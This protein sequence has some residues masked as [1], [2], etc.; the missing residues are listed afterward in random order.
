MNKLT[1]IILLLGIGLFFYQD[2]FGQRLSD[3]KWLLGVWEQKT[4]KRV[5]YETWKRDNDTCYS[6]KSYSLKEKDTIV[7]ESVRLLQKSGTLYYIP[8]VTNQNSG[9][10][11][12]F[13]LVFSSPGQLVFENP[14][15]DFPQKITYTIISS[16]SLLAEISGM[17]N[18][19]QQSRKFP[20]KR[21]H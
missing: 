13:K 21:V 15:H 8:T 6:G 14:T 11:V 3:A 4:P 19:K 16:D 12:A 18:D 5:I 1:R 9:M 20:M 10:P 2:G 7:L 17:L